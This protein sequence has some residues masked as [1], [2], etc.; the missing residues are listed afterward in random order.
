M[1]PNNPTQPNPKPNPVEHW[2]SILREREIIKFFHY[3]QVKTYIVKVKL[4][5]DIV[6]HVIRKSR[7]QLSA[8]FK[9]E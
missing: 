5:A 4:F 3:Q 9:K 2:N 6:Q 8:I 1:E 7:V